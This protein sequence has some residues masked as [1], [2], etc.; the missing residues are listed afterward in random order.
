MSDLKFT[1]STDAEHD[2]KLTSSLIYATW[3]SGVA[4]GGQKVGIEVG[5]AFVGNGA[6]I[7]IKGKS[8]NGKKLGKIKDI[9]KN[10]KYVGELEIPEDIELGD[11]VYFEVKLSKNGLDGESDRIPA[12][13]PVSVTNL[14]WNKNEARRGDVLTLTADLAG[15]SNGTEVTI[16]I[17]EHDRD[18]AHDRI[19]EF[20]ATINGSKLEVSWEYEYLEDTDEIPSQEEMEEY[21]TDYNPPEYFFTVKIGTE[22]FGQE[23][24]SGLLKFKD[25]IEISFCD[26]DGKPRAGE[27]YQLKLADGTTL[28]GKLDGDGLARIEDVPPGPVRVEFPDSPGIQVSD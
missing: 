3:Q 1:K 4:Y 20:P 19:A 24:E 9:I 12:Q 23:Q 27:K 7:K 18:S 5:T 6:K 13:P 15:V 2:I 25:W 10:N 16:I 17:Y 14:A 21:G 26:R 8:I 11:E 28:D 22:E